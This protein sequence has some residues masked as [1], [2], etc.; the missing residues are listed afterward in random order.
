MMSNKNKVIHLLTT[1]WQKKIYPNYSHASYWEGNREIG[2]YHNQY[3]ITTQYI[4]RQLSQVYLLLSNNYHPI[5]SCAGGRHSHGFV[6]LQ[7]LWSLS[8]RL[9]YTA[10]HYTAQSHLVSKDGTL[11]NMEQILQWERWKGN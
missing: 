11:S 8:L 5:Q 4:V 2:C 1:I 9:Q 7:I 6:V 3:H 10:S